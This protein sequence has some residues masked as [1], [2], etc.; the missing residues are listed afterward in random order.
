MVVLATTVFGQRLWIGDAGTSGINLRLQ[1][2]ED[3][4]QK[5]GYEIGYSQGNM[6]MI[7]AGSNRS[8]TRNWTFGFGAR[9]E[10]ITNRLIYRVPDSIVALRR[11]QLAIAID[12]IRTAFADL[13]KEG[14][15]SHQYEKHDGCAD[16]ID[17]SIGFFDGKKDLMARTN[18][19]GNH[20]FFH[21]AKEQA[22]FSYHKNCDDWDIGNYM[23]RYV[24]DNRVSVRSFDAAAF[25]KHIQPA[26]AVLKSLKGAATYPVYWRHD[27]EYKDSLAG[28]R[29]HLILGYNN[30]NH[31]H[32]GLVTGSHYFIP[33][34]YKAET[35]ALYRQLDSLTFDYVNRYPE[36]L[37]RYSTSSRLPYPTSPIIE[38]KMYTE[39]SIN[40]VQHIPSA[41]LLGKGY[42]YDID[43]YDY[44]FFFYL[45]ED[46]L[47]ILSIT[48][49][50]EGWM[51][52][53]WQKLKSWINGKK[54]Y[55]KVVEQ[56]MK[57]QAV[58]DAIAA[59]RWRIDVRMMN[60]MRYGSRMVTP[61][62]YLELRGDTLHSYL[63]Y[64]GQAR[65]SPTLSP[66][67]GLNFEEPVLRY[68]ESQPKSKKYTQID[69]DVK[70][71]EDNYHYVIQLYDSGEATIRVRSLNRD[72][73]SFD[74]TLVTSN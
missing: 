41:K 43:N 13:S 48:S 62:F 26:F 38:Y 61:D 42:G 54:E 52:A 59:K 5:L 72:A 2:L 63:P 49:T 51:P 66:S 71:R 19:T 40:S 7:G 22:S 33:A 24:S 58:A 34:Q 57:H 1:Q 67:I 64:L 29:I 46:G 39:S 28:G 55:L 8:I 56:S 25:E 21:N 69:I 60:T 32:A 47:H 74:G 16:T 65:V 53:E 3:C 6:S 30:V 9:G 44:Y 35:N 23:H 11:Q 18:I 37:H 68:K 17:Y 45:M 31:T 14:V 70:T 20:V 10:E 4:L 50:G 27:K 15:E 36:Q 73:I 12:S